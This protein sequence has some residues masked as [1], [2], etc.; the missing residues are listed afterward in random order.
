VEPKRR[1]VTLDVIS[2]RHRP[3]GVTARV[4]LR[5]TTTGASPGNVRVAG[6][7]YLTKGKRGWQVFGYDVR[8]EAL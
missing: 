1:D 7:L 6:R 2:V 3:V 8:K 4:V 5:F